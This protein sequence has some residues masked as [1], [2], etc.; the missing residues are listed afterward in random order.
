[1]KILHII[2]SLHGGGAEKFTIDLC[3]ELAKEHEIILCSLFDI[4]DTMFVENLQKNVKLIVLHKKSGFDLSM[5]FKIYN[6]IKKEKFDIINTHL[7]AL[8]YSILPIVFTQHHFFHTLHSLA[9]KESRRF[10]RFIYKILFRYFA[11]T[12][13]A[14]S[15]QVL[16]SVHKVYGK[17]FNVL[18]DNGTTPLKKTNEFQKVKQEIEQYKDNEDT[19][20]FINIGRILP[21]KNQRMLI[22]VINQLRS[23]GENVVL[24]ILGADLYSKNEQ[25]LKELKNLANE[26]VFFLGIKR[27]IADYLLCSDAFC[28]S[29]LYEGLP[30]TLLEALSLGIVPICTP[31][32]GIVNVIDDD[33]GFIS[34]DFSAEAYHTVIKKYINLSPSEK[35][36]LSENGKILFEQKYNISQT[37]AN[38]IKLYRHILNQ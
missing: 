8:R 30:I 29:S 26:K 5:F 15:S 33:T 32:G 11:V 22:E 28:L 27:N 9:E 18:I 7:R 34:A 13:I 6:L 20:I 21:V 17:N 12:P 4:T 14:I 25:F 2:P 10:N 36:R 38:Y 31:A 3:N 19:T 35:K 23:D 16:K 1:M 24:L 37:A